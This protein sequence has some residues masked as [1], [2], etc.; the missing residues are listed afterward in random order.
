MLV[1]I[2]NFLENL[3]SKMSFTFIRTL[4]VLIYI[5]KIVQSQEVKPKLES[6]TYCATLRSE[7][8]HF[9]ITH[10]Y[11]EWGKWISQP[12]SFSE[13][14]SPTGNQFRPG[15]STLVCSSGVFMWPSGTEGY[16]IIEEDNTSLPIKIFW[17]NPSIGQFTHDHYHNK[18]VYNIT[19]TLHSNEWKWYIY[20]IYK[21]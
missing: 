20:T 3:P 21:I 4:C 5:L 12:G 1:F 9:V 10:S 7:G 17:D 8:G 13:I 2:S 18:N 14:S 15:K 19:V 11:L 16:I 6:L